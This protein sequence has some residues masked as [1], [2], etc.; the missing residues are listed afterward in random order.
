MADRLLI[1]DA[2]DLRTR[3]AAY[4]LPGLEPAGSV[5]IES[6]VARL[7]SADPS[8]VPAYAAVDLAAGDPIPPITDPETGTP[9]AVGGAAADVTG[10]AGFLAAGVDPKKLE[11]LIRA[12]VFAL[13]APGERVE[14]VLVA[15][16]GAKADRL[17][18]LE[19]AWIERP[20]IEVTAVDPTSGERETRPF[21]I[22][23]R[24][25]DAGAALFEVAFARGVL[26]PDGAP[27]LVLDLGHR[28]VRAYLFDPG[29]GTL[30]LEIVPHGG[31]SY[32]EH[33]RRIAAEARDRGRD[34]SLLR[35][36]ANGTDLLA[37]GATTRVT[38][39]FF[40]EARRELAKA[41]AGTVA[42]RLRRH[43]ERGA[44]WP[45]ALL[46]AGG[47]ALPDGAEIIAEL[48]ARGCAFQKVRTL[49][50]SP[51]PLL[52]GALAAERMRVGAA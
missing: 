6:A 8:L 44:R 29:Q 39:K 43:L 21:T 30:D 34:V 11:A 33:A 49:P 46:I 38:R 4:A 14:L 52:E 17:R 37:F 41:V 19:C 5:E 51:S 27:A 10:Y 12:L 22:L 25:V 3:A 48:R 28:T 16:P 9:L 42:L 45:A 24:V 32:L 26:E 40:E 36:L 1:V 50:R 47:L 31:A 2:G 23:P 35:Q 7:E 18:D 13:C 20:E 15:D